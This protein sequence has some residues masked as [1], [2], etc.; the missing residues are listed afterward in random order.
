MRKHCTGAEAGI[1]TLPAFGCGSLAVAHRPNEWIAP[2]DLGT[3][4]DLTE[5]LVR[6]YTTP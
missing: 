5:A 6:D 2:G 1:P 3:A 4:I